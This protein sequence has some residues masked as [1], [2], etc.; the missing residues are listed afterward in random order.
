M[1]S[2][3]RN[4]PEENRKDLLGQEAHEKIQ[5]LGQKAKTCFFCTHITA[6]QHFNTRPMSFQKIDEEGVCWF[7][8]PADS[9]KNADIQ[10]D[11]SVQLLFQGSDYSDFVTLYGRASISQDKEKIK[12]LWEPILKTWF[13]EGIDDPRITVIKVTPQD[14]YYWDTK[15][16]E[17][18]SF[19][20]KIVGAVTGKTLDDSIEGDLQP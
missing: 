11:P 20:K 12:E 9:H 1:D 10:E 16:G 17:V 3:N 4:Q 19:A 18:V 15:H 14:G 8:S 13:T 6:G 2:I 7:L 5:A